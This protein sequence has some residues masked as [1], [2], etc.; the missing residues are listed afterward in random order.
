M[1]ITVS[2]P[3]P[4]E[5]EGL[6]T[7]MDYVEDRFLFIVKDEFWSEEEKAMLM[8]EPMEVALY[9][10]Y[11]VAVFLVSGGD[12]DTSDFY[13]NVQECEWK[14]QLLSS[15]TLQA[16]LILLDQDNIVCCRR[17]V[18]FPKAD[19]Q[20]IIQLLREQNEVRYHEGEFDVNAQG[21][22]SALQPFEMQEKATVSMKF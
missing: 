12:I 10:R 22:M 16:S 5:I 13:F 14:E 21:L 3:F 15:T 20:Q 8:Q 11:D 9:Y 1:N 17:D 4:F 7:I 2:Q 18:T 19:S 6:G